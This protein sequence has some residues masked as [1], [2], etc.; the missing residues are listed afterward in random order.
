MQDEELVR[1]RQALHSKERLNSREMMKAEI[2]RLREEVLAWLELLEEAETDGRIKLC[3]RHVREKQKKLREAEQEF[4][5]ET[6]I[7]VDEFEP[8]IDASKG[9]EAYA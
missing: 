1:K 9:M 4:E 5:E 2:Y 8:W 3:K 7:E 6:G